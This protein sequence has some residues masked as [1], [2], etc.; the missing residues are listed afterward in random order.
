MN[1]YIPP[2]LEDWEKEGHRVLLAHEIGSESGDFA[3]YLSFFKI[4]KPDALPRF[5]HNLVVH[6]SDLPLGRGWSP[7]TWQILEGKNS[8][9]IVLFEA[10][11]KVD[12]GPIYLKAMLEFEGH[13]LLDELRLSLAK[14][15]I[16]LCKEFVSAYP[17][18][19][20]GAQKQNPVAGLPTYR[21]RAP[22]DSRLDINK[23]LVDQF[24]LLRVVDN[25]S[26][27]A[28]FDHLGVRYKISI[29][30]MGHS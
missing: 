24:C 15:S 7:L 30:K 28:F 18:V 4:V 17:Q 10:A 12:S 14:K 1:E 27:P 5:R 21:R 11:D 9:P 29:E 25:D 13:E 23:S 22:E 3:F 8:I 2:L 20:E 6:A 16:S 19:V 26:Y